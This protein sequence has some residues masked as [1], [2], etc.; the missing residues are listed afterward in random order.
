MYKQITTV[1][2]L[3]F[4]IG[5]I[6]CNDKDN[7]KIEK[8]FNIEVCGMKNPQWLE[9][10]VTIILNKTSKYRMV[11]VSVYLENSTEVVAIVD[12]FNSNFSKYIRFFDC[13]GKQIP[14]KSDR[15]FKYYRLHGDKQFSILWSN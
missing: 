14:Y 5:I 2:T 8:L 4:C 13:S 9:K 15:Y 3:F 11:E 12:F 10:E 7:D 1:L 6:G